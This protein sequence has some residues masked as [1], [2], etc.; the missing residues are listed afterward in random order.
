MVC[1]HYDGIGQ[2]WVIEYRLEGQL[3]RSL[4]TRSAEVREQMTRDLLKHEKAVASGL[5]MDV[6]SVQGGD[7]W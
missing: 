3:V 6:T 7:R 1:L 4:R 2:E 5:R